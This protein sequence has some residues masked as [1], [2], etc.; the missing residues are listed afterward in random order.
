LNA[1]TDTDM[2]RTVTGV[3]RFVALALAVI[4]ACAGAAGLV[5]A[6]LNGLPVLGLLSLFAVGYSVLWLR[7]FIR[8]RLLSWNQLLVPWRTR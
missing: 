8:S 4:W 2:Q 6:V 5:L 3:N 1:S 7:V